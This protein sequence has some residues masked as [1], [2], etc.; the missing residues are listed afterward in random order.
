MCVCVCVYTHT[1][2]NLQTDRVHISP[3]GLTLLEKLTVSQHVRILP[4]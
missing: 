4:F 1:H 3:I 2:T